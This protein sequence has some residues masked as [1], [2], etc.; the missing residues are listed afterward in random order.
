[1]SNP[2]SN[3]NW[4]MPTATDLVTDLPADF[5]VF[6]QA[7]D[8]S[9]A[10][11][12]GGTTGQV[13]AKASGT[14]MDFTWTAIDPLVILDAKGDLITATAAD[15]P[16]RLAVG[17]NG[18]F[19][20]ADST[21]ATGLA[22]ASVGANKNWTAIANYNFATTNAAS[23]TFSGLSGYDNYI[24][25]QSGLNFASANSSTMKI[26][27]NGDTG[28]NYIY[29][30]WA[31][32]NATINP[33]IILRTT[34]TSFDTKQRNVANSANDNDATIQISGA[35]SSGYKWIEFDGVYRE[36]SNDAPGSRAMIKGFWTGSGTITSIKIDYTQ[37]ANAGTFY[38]YGSV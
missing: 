12:K 18:Q 37:T 5:E 10:D 34:G 19:L 33:D 36:W 23:Y 11:L 29:Q 2:T 16:A 21:A 27:I 30:G 35:N 9:L 4:Q 22:W 28:S 25:L 15:T 20:A 7:V 38:L 32:A 13:L 3:F 26:T 17:S 1:M 6:G 24:I 8:T 14:D 31:N